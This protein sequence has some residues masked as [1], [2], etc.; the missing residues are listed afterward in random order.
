MRMPAL[1]T[2]VPAHLRKAHSDGLRIPLEF[3]GRSRLFT[4]APTQM[5]TRASQGDRTWARNQSA[6]PQLP[7][8]VSS[9]IRSKERAVL[10]AEATS[11]F[12]GEGMDSQVQ[13]AQHWWTVWLCGSYSSLLWGC[14]FMRKVGV[15][16]RPH[17]DSVISWMCLCLA[18][19][20]LI[21]SRST[22]FQERSPFPPIPSKSF[23]LFVVKYG[24]GL[25]CTR[26]NEK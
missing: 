23:P 7:S 24:I 3:A 17:K 8:P 5:R 25:K 15:I 9:Q 14:F 10:P 16:T 4:T 21:K 19:K 11:T 18:Q 26:V 2:H 20:R 1:L 12:H 22:T 13:L 6:S